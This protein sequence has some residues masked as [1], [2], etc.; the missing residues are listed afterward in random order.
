MRPLARGA[1]STMARSVRI[2][3]AARQSAGEAEADLSTIQIAA[4]DGRFASVRQRLV[5]VQAPGRLQVK[6]GE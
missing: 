5:H 4:D 6:A 2:R 1:V 3:L